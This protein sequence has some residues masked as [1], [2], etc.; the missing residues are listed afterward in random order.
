[1]DTTA[2][3]TTTTTDAIV[4]AAAYV[5][6]VS[7]AE[8]NLCSAAAAADATLTDSAVGIA[9]RFTGRGFDTAVAKASGDSKTTVGRLRR[10]GDIILLGGDDCPTATEIRFWVR[11]VEETAGLG[12][13]EVEKAIRES[14]SSLAAV[15]ALKKAVADVKKAAAEDRA[16]AHDDAHYLKAALST[17]TKGLE[18]SRTD[19]G[20]ELLDQ[21]AVAVADAI[22]RDAGRVSPVTV[23]GIVAA[24]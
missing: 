23:A 22:A 16:A 19:A 3:T 21:I 12:V 10:T 14:G 9:E 7:Q 11:E 5:L 20:R 1:M 2:D 18:K 15:T 8:A 4:E 6:A 13:K 17:L 24:A